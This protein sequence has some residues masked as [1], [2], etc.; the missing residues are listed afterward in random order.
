MK[1]CM[2]KLLPEIDNSDCLSGRVGTGQETQVFL[3]NILLAFELNFP[4]VYHF[5]LSE[6]G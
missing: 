5:Q 1:S 4:K 2:V 6:L 3:L